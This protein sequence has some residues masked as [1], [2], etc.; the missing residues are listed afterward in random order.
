MDGPP[1]SLADGRRL[2]GLSWTDLWNRYTALGG[3]TTPDELRRHVEDDGCPNQHEH[4]VIA[5]A[6][7]EAF[8][9]QGRDHPVA[10]RHLY[11]PPTNPAE[12]VT[13]RRPSGK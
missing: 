6:I 8:T 10:Y 2:S 12:G 11:R 4:N 5:Q 1:L 9:D 13:G 3:S 7:N